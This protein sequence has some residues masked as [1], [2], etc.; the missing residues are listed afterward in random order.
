MKSNC[1]WTSVGYFKQPGF[2]LELVI[3]VEDSVRIYQ[4]SPHG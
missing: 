4:Q 2:S 1:G 3:Q